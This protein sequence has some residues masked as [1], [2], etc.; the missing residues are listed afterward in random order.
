MLLAG[1]MTTG[2]AFFLCCFSFVEIRARGNIFWELLI[3]NTV[4]S[5]GKQVREASK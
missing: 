3:F 1:L 2:L 5:V 4:F